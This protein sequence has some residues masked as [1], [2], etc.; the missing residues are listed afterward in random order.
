MYPETEVV[1]AETG[2]EGILHA[3]TR[4]SSVI[5]MDGNLGDSTANNIINTI[6]EKRMSGPVILLSVMND[7]QTVKKLQT[8]DADAILD[9]REIW[10][11]LPLILHSLLVRQ[12]IFV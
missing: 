1:E 3:L 7:K 8:I 5:I 4:P 2:E 9:E 11:K 10:T 12:S 6:R